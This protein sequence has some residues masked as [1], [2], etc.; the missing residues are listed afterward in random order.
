VDVVTVAEDVRLHLRVPAVR[1]VTEVNT[2]FQ[3]LAHRKIGQ[4]HAL[5][6]LFRFNPREANS[7]DFSSTPPGG[8]NRISPGTS[9]ASR[10]EW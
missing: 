8:T 5:L 9:Q 6:L 10:V 4:C 1:L 7:A 2:S 3:K